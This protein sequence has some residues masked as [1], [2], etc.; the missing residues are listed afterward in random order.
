M[1][2]SVEFK[3]DVVYDFLNNPML[4]WRRFLLGISSNIIKFLISLTNE[5]CVCAIIIDDSAYYRDRSEKV[6]L[7]ARNKDH[8]TGIYYKGF[9][10]LTVGW[11]DGATFIPLACRSVRSWESQ[12]QQTSCIFYSGCVFSSLV[13]IGTLAEAG[14]SFKTVGFYVLFLV[15]KLSIVVGIIFLGPKRKL[16]NLVES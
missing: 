11:T 9:R 12:D 4:N 7:L 14:L 2:V 3:K 15:T 13:V 1:N 6:E 16:V 5:N 10:K 8:S